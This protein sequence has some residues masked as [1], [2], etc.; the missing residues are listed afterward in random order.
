MGGGER[1]EIGRVRQANWQAAKAVERFDPEGY[2]NPGGE[3]RSLARQAEPSGRSAT[4][5]KH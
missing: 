5:Q 3:W 4:G 1:E 2:K